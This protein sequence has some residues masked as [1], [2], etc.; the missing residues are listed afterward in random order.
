MSGSISEPTAKLMMGLS[1]LAA[2]VISGFF[3]HCGEQIPHSSSA[4][5]IEEISCEEETGDKRSAPKGGE[6]NGIFKEYRHILEEIIS[7]VDIVHLSEVTSSRT[8][9]SQKAVALINVLAK[10]I[11][12][13]DVNTQ[14]TSRLSPSQPS[15]GALNLVLMVLPEFLSFL[16]RRLDA[17]ILLSAA[18]LQF[19]FLAIYHCKTGLV[20]Y[21]RDFLILSNDLLSHKSP[22]VSF[23]PSGQ[24]ALVF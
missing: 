19:V 1:D 21:G 2:L 3:K 11:G 16:S 9:H 24:L 13:A 12:K 6:G 14:P 8:T 5:K 20:D 18:L 10:S 22:D 23:L 17:D 15:I 7:S 4:S